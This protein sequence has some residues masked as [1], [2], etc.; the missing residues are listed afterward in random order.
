M[1]LGLANKLWFTSNVKFRCKK[2]NRCNELQ[3]SL[4]DPRCIET[5]FEAT[6]GKI[7][8]WKLLCDGVFAS[9]MEAEVGGRWGGVWRGGR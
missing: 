6:V 9:K 4:L 5:A 7:G 2:A 1:F 8:D 3:S